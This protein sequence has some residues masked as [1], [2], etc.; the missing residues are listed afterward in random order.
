MKRIAEKEGM[1]W[2]E[3]A[4]ED[5]DTAKCLINNKKW[6]MVCF[7]SQQIA[8]KALKAYLYYK[9]EKFVIGHSVTDLCKWANEIDKSFSH[10]IDKIS[11]LD[12][13]YLPTRYPNSLPSNIPKNVYN[14]KSARES[15]ELANR[16][17]KFV[18]KKM[19][20]Y[21]K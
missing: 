12:G 11:I 6:Y 21:K 19:L 9:G 8:E 13:Y 15:L 7:L 18:S 5:F 16:T 4:N 1:R 20:R 2:L 10:L 3:Q 17:I 14:E